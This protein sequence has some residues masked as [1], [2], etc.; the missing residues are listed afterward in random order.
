MTS[1]AGESSFELEAM[2]EAVF[3]GLRGFSALTVAGGQPDFTQIG[4]RTLL[5][6]EDALVIDAPGL[7]G[8]AGTLVLQLEIEGSGTGTGTAAPPPLTVSFLDWYVG[9]ATT[10][11]AFG[12]IDLNGKSALASVSGA[13]IPFV[14]GGPPVDILLTTIVLAGAFCDGP[15]CVSWSAS[16][17]T[18]AFNTVRV[19]GIEAYDE[20][21]AAV[22]DFAIAAGSGSLYSGSGITAVPEPAPFWLAAAALAATVLQR[23]RRDKRE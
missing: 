16:V 22:R 8:T 12:R 18:D 1:G 13:P 21:G 23:A 9:P 15:H 14:Y 10:S 5:R 11:P 3:G 4:W 17:E 6:M 7:T 20:T 19:T 2:G